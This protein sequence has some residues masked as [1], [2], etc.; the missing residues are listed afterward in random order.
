[1]RV[2]KSDFILEIEPNAANLRDQLM[3]QV[4]DL[5][6]KLTTAQIKSEVYA[7]NVID[8]QAAQV[9]AVGGAVELMAAA[10]AKWDAELQ[11]LPG[12]EAKVLQAQLNHDRQKGLMK[13]GIKAEVEIENSRKTGM[14]PNRTLSR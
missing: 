4:Q 8:F 9:A 6:A 5:D 7:Q 14:S 2:K 3:S 12:Y 1:M 13:K 10:K 11:L